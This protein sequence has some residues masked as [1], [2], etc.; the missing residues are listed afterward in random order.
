MHARFIKNFRGRKILTEKEVK[1]LL[2]DYEIPT[3]NYRLVSYEEDLRELNL[4]YP[5]VLKVCSP[6]Y[7]HKTEVGGVRLNIKSRAELFT[8]FKEFKKKFTNE[9]FLV[10]SM[11]EHGLELIIGAVEDYT[12]GHAIMLGLG[13]VYTELFK[14]VTF[15]VVPIN[16]KDAEEMIME[17][18]ASEFVKGFRGM[19][20]SPKALINILLKTSELTVDY[21]DYIKELDLNPVFVREKDAVVVDARMV[22]R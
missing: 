11:E 14:D 7:T 15:R 10:E 5:L 21:Q 8:A 12:F 22:L 16:S 1:D 2:K 6:R 9:R 19:K 18:K 17:I 3:T 4:E 13:G 20:I